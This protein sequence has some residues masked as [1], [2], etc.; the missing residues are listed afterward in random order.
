[1]IRVGYYQFRPRFG[2]TG[3]NCRKI[4]KRLRDVD[5]DLMVLPELPFTGYLFSGLPEL[6]A[7]AE[8]P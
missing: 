6:A 2:D 8:D 3:G 1:M 5:A 4:V 7:L